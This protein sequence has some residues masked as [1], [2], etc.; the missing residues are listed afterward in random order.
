MGFLKKL[1]L[2]TSD[3]P[4][5]APKQ[6]KK[7]VSKGDGVFPPKPSFTNPVDTTEYKNLL[8][9]VLNKRDQPGPDFLEFYKALKS[10]DSQPLQ[11]QQKYILAFSALST[12]GLTKDKITS[13]ATIYTKA[14]D[15]EKVEFDKSLEQYDKNEIVA[16]QT[17]YQRLSDENVKLTKQIQDNMA[18]MSKLSLDIGQ[19]KQN[20]TNKQTAFNAAIEK[21]KANIAEIVTNIQTYI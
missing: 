6:N 1:G 2:V 21:E 20:Y 13:T 16:K 11:P 8:E 9:E 5:E 18:S 19:N 15:N 12:M 10:F 3:E 4:E 14:L 17:E 7:L